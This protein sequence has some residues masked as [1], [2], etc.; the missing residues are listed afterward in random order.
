[1]SRAAPAVLLLSLALGACGSIGSGAGA[2]AGLATGAGTANPIVG[3]SVALGTKAAVDSLVRYI[4]RKRQQGEQDAIAEVVGRLPLGGTAD[5]KI[6]HS[7]P[8]GNE[9]GTLLVAR[10]I[11]NPL[12]PCREVVF[13]VQDGQDSAHY[14]TTACE[15]P[16]AEGPRWAWA[17][18]E[19]TTARWGFLQ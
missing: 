18:A 11:I 4:S 15:L 12:A 8:I 10:E 6:E 1:M 16:S 3:A 14:V 9:H 7:I 5:W 13:T 19:P 2:V 17:Q